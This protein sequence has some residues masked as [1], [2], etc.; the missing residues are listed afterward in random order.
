MDPKR[1]GWWV[2]FQQDRPQPLLRFKPL[3]SKSNWMGFPPLPCHPV[4]QVEV[5]LGPLGQHNP[6][7]S[8]MHNPVHVLSAFPSGRF[9]AISQCSIR[10]MRSQA[11]RLVVP[12]NTKSQNCALP[13]TP[14]LYLISFLAL[15]PVS[16]SV[17]PHFHKMAGIAPG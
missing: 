17:V 3:V 15:I 14:Q 8:S 13:Y 5:V 4:P 12:P 6:F 10:P 11:L 7:V 1:G 2:R 9:L 16:Q